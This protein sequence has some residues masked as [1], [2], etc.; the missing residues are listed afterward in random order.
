[1]TENETATTETEEAKDKLE[2]AVR[3]CGDR[4]MDT[5]ALEALRLS[6]FL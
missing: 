4:A 2:D 6:I 1:M 3:R 5:E